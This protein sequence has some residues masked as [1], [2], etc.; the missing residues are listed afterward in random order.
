MALSDGTEPKDGKGGDRMAQPLGAAVEGPLPV[1]YVRGQPAAATPPL[2]AECLLGGQAPDCV[3]VR[4]T[5]L[6]GEVHEDWVTLM[7]GVSADAGDTVLMIQPGNTTRPL[8]AGVAV[9]PNLA[10]VEKAAA[11]LKLAPGE[12]VRVESCDGAGLLEVFEGPAGPVV[13]LLQ[14]DVTVEAPGHLKLSAERLELESRQGDTS[15]Q[16]SGDVLVTGKFVRLN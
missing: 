10:K 11:S 7:A 13:R 1:Y 2:V 5:D 3:R 9:R 14:R 15:I 16:A 6:R 8:V 4:W 12:H